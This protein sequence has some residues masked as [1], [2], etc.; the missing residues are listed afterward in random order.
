M[1]Q[2]F[3]S[4]AGLPTIPIH[5]DK[6]H[7]YGKKNACWY[8]FFSNYG[9]YGDWSKHITE[10][11]RKDGYIESYIDKIK[12]QES[13]ALAKQQ[14]AERHERIA[15][16]AL[17]AVKNCSNQGI[18]E[19]LQKKQL[20]GFGELYSGNSVVFPLQ[21]ASGKI[22]TY[23]YIKGDQ[24][25]FLSGGK[26]KACFFPIGEVINNDDLIVVC[27]GV[28][29]G[30]AIHKATKLPIICAMDAGNIKAVCDSLPYTNIIIA[31]DNDVSDAGEKAAIESGYKYVMPKTKGDDF[32]D[33]WNKAEDLKYYFFEN[34]FTQNTGEIKAHG[35]VGEIAN[36]ILETAVR[37]Q[38]ELALG[39]AIA[40]V[41]LIKGQKFTTQTGLCS[42]MLILNLAP[43][44]AGKEH[45]Q[46][47]IVR[48][49]SELGLNRH[50]MGEPTSGAA[51]IT[52]LKKGEGR[53]LFV[54]DEAGRYLEVVNTPK[55][56]GYQ[57]EV[58]RYI[59]ATFSK[60]NSKFVTKQYKDDKENPQENIDKPHFCFIGSSIKESVAAACSSANAIDG[61]LNRFL[62]FEAETRPRKIFREEQEQ[63]PV[64]LLNKISSV[65]S[66]ESKK[67]RMDAA[68]YKIFINFDNDNEDKLQSTKHPLDAL[69]SRSSEIVMKLSLIFCDNEKIKERDVSLAIEVYK[70]TLEKQLLFVGNI[71][72]NQTHSDSNKVYNFIKKRK[73]VGLNEIADNHRHLKGSERK[74]I[75]NTLLESNKIAEQ[76]QGKKVFYKTTN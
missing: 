31:A 45:P 76:L 64:Q 19:Y 28:A 57:A 10:K 25:R 53:S 62:I 42:N 70:K 49:I 32:W 37:P 21:D 6:I 18:S 72:D 16:S 75:L 14:E 48:L 73:L 13:I 26:K 38:P 33:A 39:A 47:C 65:I 59:V 71:S 36:W 4:F 41:G 63:I 12:I 55:A 7:R 29:T 54:I 61:F 5:D 66:A 67:I 1:S 34:E 46:N 2:D 52:G 3:Q 74:D 30:A 51:F 35:L 9:V 23:Q 69:Y 43:T 50:L 8:V 40:F 68:A 20:N 22:W 11:W 56:Q 60:A 17:K 24:K 15:A 58:I 27:E 44:G